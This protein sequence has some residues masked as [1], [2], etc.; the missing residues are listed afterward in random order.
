MG[1]HGKARE[2]GGMASQGGAVTVGRRKESGRADYYPAGKGWFR[3]FVDSVGAHGKE[4]KLDVT[5]LQ[6]LCQFFWRLTKTHAPTSL[7]G[8][9]SDPARKNYENSP[10]TTGCYS[11]ASGEVLLKS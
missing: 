2:H 9:G 10:G 5:M 7:L 6:K 11:I 1:R 8:S 4:V 3:N